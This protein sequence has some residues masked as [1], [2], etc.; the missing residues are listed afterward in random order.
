[1]NT[2]LWIPD[3]FMK[4]LQDISEGRLPKDAHGHYSVQMKHLTSMKFMEASLRNDIYI[5]KNLQKK[6][7]YMAIKFAFLLFGKK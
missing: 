4:R 6:G 7:K 2:A 5:M 3:L 1:M